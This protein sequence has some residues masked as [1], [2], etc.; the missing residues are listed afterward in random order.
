M[1]VDIA[2]LQ[3]PT[4]KK[5]YTQLSGGDF[6]TNNSF[7]TSLTI[8]LFGDKRAD[9]SEVPVVHHRRGWWGNEFNTNDP[10]FQLGSKLWLLHQARATPSTANKAVD[11]VKESLQW[12]IDDGHAQR[13]NVTSALSQNN[14]Q[15]TITIFRE[16][17]VTETRYYD[18]WENTGIV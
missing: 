11:Y 13:V 9:A 3:D 7:D 17:G 2:I 1:T 12:L 4:T 15:L 14:I 6:L 10:E 16:A 5:F 8:S 18:L